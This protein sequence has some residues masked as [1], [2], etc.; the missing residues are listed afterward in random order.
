[1]SSLTIYQSWKQNQN[2]NCPFFPPFLPCWMDDFDG[3]M[4]S[5]LIKSVWTWTSTHTHLYREAWMSAC[6]EKLKQFLSFSSSSRYPG[7]MA[8]HFHTE[9]HTHT[10]THRHT[11]TRSHSLTQSECWP[12]EAENRCSKL[13]AVDVT[14]ISPLFLLYSPLVHV[15]PIS[16]SLPPPPLLLL[17]HFSLF[18]SSLS[19]FFLPF[20]PLWLGSTHSSIFSICE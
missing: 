11:R 2:Q 1:M 4:L 13:D 6:W 19:L 15:T 17:S 20:P 14:I 12:L 5:I 18:I 8:K 10:H 9:T 3:K 7:K 16:S